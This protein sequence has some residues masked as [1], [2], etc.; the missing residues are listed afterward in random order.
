M[1]E[2]AG[3]FGNVAR[4]YN[5]ARPEYADGALSRAAEVLELGK[6]A[7]VVDLAAGTGKLTRRLLESFGEVVAVEPDDRMR[8]V[9]E[10]TT[11]G[12][13]ARAGT[14]EG[15]PLPDA[16]ADAVFAADSFH[17]FDGAV[18][19]GEITR[20]LRPRGGLA[21]LWNL[22]WSEGE[23]DFEHELDPPLPDA[24]QALLDEA[25]VRSGRVDVF[26]ERGHGLEAFEGSRFGPVHEEAFRK[27]LRLTG[28]EVVALFTSVSSVAWLPEE[29]REE[30]GR[31]LRALVTG[32]HR[33]PMTTKLFWTRLQ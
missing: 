28:N 15:I 6:D 27:E 25:Y 9:L 26:R 24:A 31:R 16:S 33:L 2:L 32:M 18:A 5:E 17:W 7:R 3:S 13:D 1:E 22:W 20:V 23:D 11:P 10:A 30:L 14:A 4:A 29:E 12:A 21:L 8:A 19:V